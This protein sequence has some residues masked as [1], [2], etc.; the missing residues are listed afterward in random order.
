VSQCVI[1]YEPVWAISTNPNAR[2]DTPASAVQAMSLIRE[3]LADQFDVSHP[4]FLYG[5][6]V[7]PDNAKEFLDR[8]EIYG[9]LVGGASVRPADFMGIVSGVSESLKP[10]DL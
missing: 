10:I 3:A 7:H 5:G 2:P 9:V 6:S 1:A 4:T 8:P